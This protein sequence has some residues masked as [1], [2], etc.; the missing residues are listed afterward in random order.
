[1]DWKLDDEA[2]SMEGFIAIMADTNEKITKLIELYGVTSA[3]GFEAI[4][5][6]MEAIFQPMEELQSILAA[7]ATEMVSLLRLAELEAENRKIEEQERSRADVKRKRRE[8]R[9]QRGRR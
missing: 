1:M 5:V 4:K 6:M 9:K 7:A 3:E 8:M 2:L